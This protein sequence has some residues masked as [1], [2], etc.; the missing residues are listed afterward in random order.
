MSTRTG[1]VNWKRFS[2][3][4]RRARRGFTVLELLIVC[5]I[6]AILVMFALPKVNFTQL[7][8][9]AGARLVRITLQNAQRLAVTRQYDVVVSFDTVTKR[10]RVLEDKN[11]NA[12][13]DSDERVTWRALEDSVRFAVPPSGMDGAAAGAPVNGTNLKSVDGMPS[14]IFRRD[15]AA[16]TDVDVYVTSRRA[17]ADDYRGIRVVQSTGRTEWRKYVGGQWRAAS[18]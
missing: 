14:V 6:I 8:V 5:S 1:L 7:Q 4:S 12:T 11:N 10:I 15:G 13:V 3:L 9:D 17:K 18:L 2:P 16:S